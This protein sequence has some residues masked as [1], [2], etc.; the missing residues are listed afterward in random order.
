MFRRHTCKCVHLQLLSDGE[1]S[2]TTTTTERTESRSGNWGNRRRAGGRTRCEKRRTKTSS[3]PSRKGP[4]LFYPPSGR[5]PFLISGT[6]GAV[7]L[8]RTESNYFFSFLFFFLQLTRFRARADDYGVSRTRVCVC[9]RERRDRRRVFHRKFDVRP[10]AAR[11]ESL[12]TTYF[13]LHNGRK[14]GMHTR[15]NTVAREIEGTRRREK[16]NPRAR[17]FVTR[18]R[19]ISNSRCAV[20]AIVVVVDFFFI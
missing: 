1:E 14:N 17:L 2:T 13:I 8:R 5:R 11:P 12:T 18:D 7:S 16:K 15:R 4:L 3:S 20:R 9:I 6:A 19:Y 10:P